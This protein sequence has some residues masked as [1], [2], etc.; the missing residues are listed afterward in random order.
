MKTYIRF[1]RGMFDYKGRTSRGEYVGVLLLHGLL[2]FPLLIAESLLVVW[3]Y[4]LET[5][6]SVWN[7]NPPGF[8]MIS[9][10]FLIA[11]AAATVRRLND[12][13]YSWRSLG[14]LLIPIVGW[15]AF[16]GRIW[17]KSVE[18]LPKKPRF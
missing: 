13:G 17:N 4:D 8:W 6:Q 1:W 5:L 16:A 14:W 15:V 10:A 9:I 12:G 11:Y 18:Q 7:G 2:T 3:R